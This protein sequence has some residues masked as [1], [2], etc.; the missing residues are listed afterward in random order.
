MNITI[1]DAKLRELLREVIREEFLKLSV[2]LIPYISS[3]EIND[4]NNTHTDNEFN[5][6]DNFINLNQWLG[7]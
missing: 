5:D 3:E 7:R 4:I 6:T 1:D 2:S